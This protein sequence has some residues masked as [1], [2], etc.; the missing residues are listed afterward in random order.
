MSTASLPPILLVG[1]GKMGSAML[2]GWLELGVAEVVV[3][4][5]A[6]A[7]L[8][9]A[10]G[11]VR[12]VA[13]AA[14]IPAD[15]AAEAIVLAIKPQMAAALLPAYAGRARHAV[16]LSIMAGQT[17]A[18]LSNLLSSQAI[19]RAMPNTPA[20]VRQGYT[21]ATAGAG[22]AA[23]AR[24][25]CDQLLASVGEVA[26]VDNEALLDPVTAISGGGP[27]Y[28]FLLA[29]L[30]EQAGVDLGLPAE[31]ARAMARRTVS[32]SGALLAASDLDAAELRRNVTSP[33][34]T[35][36]RAL[37]VLMAS[38]AWPHAVR[39]AMIAA[40]NRSRELAG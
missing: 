32:G 16:C 34:G 27:A 15:F 8:A 6:P 17:I 23:P 7:A 37:A 40:T 26:W 28:V 20:A 2:T 30:L 33:G 13:D 1:G 14:D 36:E 39:Q 19:V 3:V 10:G 5:P 25:L 38:D 35:T 9:L 31:L 21:V 11:P 12:V 24:A 18:R 22:V 29:E 4:D